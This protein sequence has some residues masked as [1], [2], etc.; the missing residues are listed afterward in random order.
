[1]LFH[2]I[3]V[4]ALHVPSRKDCPE[5]VDIS[6][7]LDRLSSLPQKVSADV[8]REIHVTDPRRVGSGIAIIT[9]LRKPT[10][11]EDPPIRQEEEIV[12]RES[13]LGLPF[14]GDPPQG[15]FRLFPR[16]SCFRL[17]DGEV[18]VLHFSE[19]LLDVEDLRLPVLQRLEHALDEVTAELRPEHLE[20]SRV[21]HVQ[22][23]LEV[24]DSEIRSE[25]H[26]SELQSRLHLVCRLL[27][28]KKK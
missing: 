24:L 2:E 9:D 12:L 16:A 17:D 4:R 23:L 1:M 13:V 10:V 15:R 26:T 20:P 8:I 21:P 18:R 22:R 6:S 27:L 19:D 7:A 25:E 5:I 28:E 11:W 3:P 14:L